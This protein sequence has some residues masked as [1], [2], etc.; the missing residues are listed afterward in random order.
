L[1]SNATANPGLISIRETTCPTVDYVEPGDIPITEVERYHMLPLDDILARVRA[2]K[3]AK[4]PV[5]GDLVEAVAAFI[6][7]ELNTDLQP[8]GAHAEMRYDPHAATLYLWSSKHSPWR[9][10]IP[11]IFAGADPDH[12][13]C[14]RVVMRDRS[15]ECD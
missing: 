14:I 15:P 5:P 2:G 4:L 6:G 3:V 10:M 8:D 11:P 13:R 12:P 1:I 7:E 9:F